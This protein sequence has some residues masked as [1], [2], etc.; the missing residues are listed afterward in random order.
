MVAAGHPATAAAA[1]EI[2]RAGGNAYDAAVAGL[3]AACIA[4]PVLAS[5][6]G[7]GF[8]LAQPASGPATL[9]DFFAQTPGR[10]RPADELDFEPVMADFGAVQQEFHTGLGAIATPGMVAGLFDIN[11]SLGRLPMRDL[12]APAI[13]LARDGLPVA[14]M[15]SFIKHAVTP[16]LLYSPAAKALFESKTEAGKTLQA[17]EIF[18]MAELA[19]CLDAL[20][21]EGA[22]L[23]YEGEIA[24]SIENQAT[25][26]GGSLRRTDLESYQVIHRPPLRHSFAGYEVLSNPA[27]SSGG[28]LIAFALAL[29]KESAAGARPEEAAW[30]DQLTHAMALTNDA[31]R[32]TGL[33]EQVDD[34]RVAR[35]LDSPH[36]S[37]HRH[38]MRNRALKIGGTTHLSVIDGDGNAAAATV[39]NGEGCGHIL[40]GCGFMLN[41]MLGEED[42][43]PRGFFNWLPD[44]RI[45]SMMSPTLVNRGNDQ[46]FA[47]GSGGSNRIRTAILQ[48]LCNRLAFDIEFAEA[49][50]RPRLH[51]ER[52]LLHI[53]HG[54]G[55]DLVDILCNQYHDHKVWPER[56]FFFG[57]VHGVELSLA[58]GLNGAGDSRRGGVAVRA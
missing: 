18:R 16:I 27:P 21:Q 31:R 44:Q 7:G 50:E 17:G 2:L 25:G 5:L 19:D 29:L 56:N 8:L 54:F 30:L 12:F 40:P 49:V 57:G 41:N 23:F 39:S 38:A 42:I 6:G 20:G 9:F 1:V 26:H 45:S 35:L 53:E 51:Y 22:R 28:P 4:E 14:E 37:E 10:A 34:E 3:S 15:Q 11:E 52:G 24:A 36:L 13:T 46:R 55:E 48:V 47:L 32:A 58:R 33:D 43:N